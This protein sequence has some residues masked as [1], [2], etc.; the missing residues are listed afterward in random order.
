MYT[1]FRACM[2]P[3]VSDGMN[4]EE[5]RSQLF[6]LSFHFRLILV[7]QLHEE[8]KKL[9][10][11]PPNNTPWEEISRIISTCAGLIKDEDLTESDTIVR[12]I[13]GKIDALTKLEKDQELRVIVERVISE[14]S[15]SFDTHLLSYLRDQ[16]EFFK[17]V[18]GCL[19]YRGQ[20]W[21]QFADSKMEAIEPEKLERYYQDN[22]KPAEGLKNLKIFQIVGRR[23]N[24]TIDQVN[25]QRINQITASSSGDPQS[26][27]D[28]E[29]K[30][31]YA[32]DRRKF[33]IMVNTCTFLYGY[34]KVSI[35]PGHTKGKLETPSFPVAANVEEHV[36]VR[37]VYKFDS[38]AEF[39][40]A[41]IEQDGHHDGH[42]VLLYIH[43]F[44]TSDKLAIRCAAQ[45]KYDL[46]F[47]GV[48]LAYCWP[49]EGTYWGY[50]EDE[51][52]VKKTAQN[53][54]QVIA[55]LLSDKAKGISRVHILA[56][57]MGN[58]ALIKALTPGERQKPFQKKSR[59]KN[60]ILAAADE[61]RC[62]FEAMLQAM[63]PEWR[64]ATGSETERAENP[65]ISVY[66]STE[67]LALRT[68]EILHREIRLGN[69]NSL[70]EMLEWEDAVDVVDA[71]GVLCAGTQHSYHAEVSN[72]LD[73]IQYLLTNLT[74]ASNR[75]ALPNPVISV[76]VSAG[77]RTFHAFNQDRWP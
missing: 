51:K 22:A 73:D 75:A 3:S 40:R 69:T 58:R 54:H 20:E 41:I 14:V 37:G 9:E 16:H 13:S 42:H 67:D 60:V 27:M 1:L 4:P 6:Y 35:P 65:L 68:S 33:D 19:P 56:H 24:I 32:T 59:F 44:K 62:K 26:R 15:N 50:F 43:G 29:I 38:E 64:N 66:S 21:D 71:S 61:K 7:L 77:K 30:V 48:V 18:E 52:T 25:N 47:T 76:I 45:L 8:M 12:Q 53:L 10:P 49:S 55:T 5:R 31:F 28:G 2:A 70:R 23:F 11:F 46:G 34:A 74:G 36:T 72:V 17:P 57:S 39:L 63:Y